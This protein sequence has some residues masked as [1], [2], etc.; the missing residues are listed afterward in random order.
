VILHNYISSSDSQQYSAVDAKMESF[1]PI[2]NH[3]VNLL[4]DFTT[5]YGNK[6]IKLQSTGAAGEFQ[7]DINVNN[8]V[9]DNEQL[10]H[11]VR[12][13]PLQDDFKTS[14]A[15]FSATGGAVVDCSVT[16]AGKERVEVAAGAFDSYRVN[17]SMRS[18]EESPQEHSMWISADEH[19][20][21]TKYIA[22]LTMILELTEVTAAEKDAPL[23]F[24]DGELGYSIAVP[25]DWRFYKH[26]VGAGSFVELLASELKAK[27]ALCVLAAPAGS[28]A[29][30]IARRDV[31][32]FK[33]LFQ[34]YTVRGDEFKEVGIGRLKAVQYIADLFEEGNAA[35]KYP[36]PKEMVEYRTYI[37]SDEKVYFFVFRAIKDKFDSLRS[38]FDAIIQ[39]FELKQTAQVPEPNSV[40]VT[41]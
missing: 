20:Y 3:T 2:F 39:S 4:G 30:D 1:R 11:L 40:I 18:G 5:E 27:G 31:E 37:T 19:R 25:D 14:F 22:G 28:K 24:E 35:W 23:T 13:M 33:G 32:T 34:G 21:L 8:V 6:K 7:K 15:L 29:V 9:Y 38:E 17:L 10:V 12:R 36:K 16:V 41:Q 26:K